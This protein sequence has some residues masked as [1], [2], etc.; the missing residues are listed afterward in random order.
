MVC[1]SRA[2]CLPFREGYGNG[3]IFPKE[4]VVEAVGKPKKRSQQSSDHLHGLL[5][6][7]RLPWR[8]RLEFKAVFAEMR[9]PQCE[10]SVLMNSWAACRIAFLVSLPLV[11]MDL[12]M[13]VVVSARSKVGL[14]KAC[15]L[16]S[17]AATLCLR[18]PRPVLDVELHRVVNALLSETLCVKLEQLAVVRKEE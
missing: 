6:R 2:F 12:Q 15:V 5:N 1:M 4:R 3:L 7:T 10:H 16:F 17:V 9:L 18:F 8:E 11:C 14:A 13:S